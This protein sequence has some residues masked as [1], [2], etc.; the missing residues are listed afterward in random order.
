VASNGITL[1][2]RNPLTRRCPNQFVE[3]VMA[4]DVFA[5]EQDGA[6]RAAKGRRMDRSVFS[7]HRLVVGEAA[8]SQGNGLGRGLR[9]GV[10][11]RL[12]QG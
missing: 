10:G 3:R 1:V 11:G 6:I 8:Q 12:G 9:S 5:G 2:E 7:I 4:S